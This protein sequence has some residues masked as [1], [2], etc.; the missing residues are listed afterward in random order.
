MRVTWQKLEPLREVNRLSSNLFRSVRHV[1]LWAACG[2]VM[3]PAA[4]QPPALAPPDPKPDATLPPAPTGFD[5]PLPGI[6]R[7]SI[8]R[9]T[10]HST[11]T[12]SERPA[13][14]YLP[15]GY[16][17]ANDYPVLYLLHGIGGN[18]TD[19][20]EQGKADAILDNLIAADSAVPMIVVMPNGRATTKPQGSL[21]LPSDRADRAPPI[22]PNADLATEMQAYGAFE[23][24]LVNDL[25]PYIEANY[26]VNTQRALAGLSMGGGQSLNVGLGK[27][28][29]FGWV[30]G[31]SS[32]PNTAPAERLVAD[33]AQLQG[34]ELIWLAC[35]NEDSLY[36]LTLALHERLD[37]N[38][39]DHVWHVNE[40]EHTFTQW[41]NDLYNFA[42]LLFR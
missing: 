1:L 18:E 28:G 21:F 26:P 42:Q 17:T 36:G 32:A 34:L 23:Q 9:I 38:A 37:A 31:F 35:G 41:K 20:T 6:A 16:S 39:V 19:W 12:D 14:V 10:F 13:L 33:P 15:P 24:E 22:D 5:V 27:A 4:A 7:G 25:V 2:L 8:E 11:V 40:G 30:G 3:H 29:S